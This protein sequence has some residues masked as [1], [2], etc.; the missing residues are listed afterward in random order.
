MYITAL[1]NVLNVLSAFLLIFGWGPV[2][3]LELQGAAL[4]TSLARTVGG[5][6]ALGVLFSPRSPVRLRLAHVLRW[7]GRLLWRI[8]RIAL[9]NVAETIISRL[10]FILFTR[11]LASLGTV[12]LAAHQVAL[13]IESLAFMPGWGLATAAAAV[14][15]QA[16]GAQEVDVAEMSIRRTLVIGNAIMVMLAVIFVSFGSAIVRIFG[17]RDPELVRGAVALIRISSLELIGLCSVMILGGCM[18]GAGDTRTPMIVT[19]V[20]TVLFRVPITYLFVLVL[21][22]GLSGVWLATAVDWSM[23]AL[24]LCV[25]YLRGRWKTVTV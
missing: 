24:I 18:R 25:L 23:R 6:V 11:I 4:S 10:G 12:A 16:L 8:M 21:D 9:P 13:R 15:G 20:G 2:P 22:G 5:L 7:D 1:M 3:R 17:L 19:L 14:V